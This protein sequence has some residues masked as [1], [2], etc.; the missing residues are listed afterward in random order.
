MVI[1]EYFCYLI[2]LI[3]FALKPFFIPL[4]SYIIIPLL[5]LLILYYVFSMIYRFKSHTSNTIGI[6]TVIVLFSLLCTLKLYPFG[7]Y[8]LFVAIV[9]CVVAIIFLIKEKKFVLPNIIALLIAAFCLFSFKFMDRTDRYYLWNVKYNYNIEHD[10]VIWDKYSWTLYKERKYDEALSANQQAMK[11]LQNKNNMQL[12]E[13]VKLN[14]EKISS[15]TWYTAH[16]K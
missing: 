2:I 10:Y 6:A 8:V 3:G 11:I 4:A 12:L 13:R 7:H 15:K 5:A 9:S 1:F 16:Y 14:R